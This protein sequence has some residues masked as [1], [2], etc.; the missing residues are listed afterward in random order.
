M[1]ARKGHSLNRYGIY[2]PR[3]YNKKAYEIR[4]IFL[5]LFSIM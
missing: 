2:G 1:N 3:G 5:Y 4:Q